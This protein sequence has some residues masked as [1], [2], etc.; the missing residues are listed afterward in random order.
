[1]YKAFIFSGLVILF[2]NAQFVGMAVEFQIMG[3]VFMSLI[4]TNKN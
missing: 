3:I 1:M 4:E 2:H